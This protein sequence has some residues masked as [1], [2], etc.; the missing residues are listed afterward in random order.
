ME[1]VVR[2]VVLTLPPS[3]RPPRFLGWCAVLLCRVVVEGSSGHPFLFQ[4]Q[5]HLLAYSNWMV[6]CLFDHEGDGKIALVVMVLL[7][8]L[9]YG[10]A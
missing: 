9:F 3:G 4:G 5:F 8:I 1:P 7:M 2:Q 10:E 6:A